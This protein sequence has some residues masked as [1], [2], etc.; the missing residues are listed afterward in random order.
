MASLHPPLLSPVRVWVYGL[1]ISIAC[2]VYA[3]VFTVAS[4]ILILS[5]LALIAVILVATVQLANWATKRIDYDARLETEAEML[6]NQLQ[7]LLGSIPNPLASSSQTDSIN[8]LAL[9]GKA[10]KLVV[11]TSRLSPRV[12]AEMAAACETGRNV[13]NKLRAQRAQTTAVLENLDSGVLVINQKGRVTLINAAAKNFFSISW[14]PVG[15]PLVEAIRQPELLNAV[16]QVMT[17]RSPR[18]VV[19]DLRD[20]TGTRRVLRVWCAAVSFED[21]TAVLLA[22]RDE[23]ENHQVEE[24]RREFV[25]NVSHE[26]K[27]PLAAIKGYAETVELAISDDPQAAIHFVS[28]IHEQCRRLE[29]LIADMM[30]LARAQAGKQHLRPTTIDLDAVIAESIATYAPVA[31]AKAISLRHEPGHEAAVVYAD[32][33]ATLTIANNVIGNAIRYTPEGGEV[34][35]SSRQEGDFSVF[36]VRDN[37]IGIPQ[38]EQQKVFERFY[39]ADKSRKHTSS[40]TGLGLAIVKN[41]TLAQG[42]RVRLQ[43]RPGKGSTFEI[44]LPERQP[45][46]PPTVAQSPSP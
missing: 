43:S 22:A 34:V 14:N 31:T 39:R 21:I 42:G 5:T 46:Q 38:H 23:S 15:K 2:F 12:V 29:R 3:I 36:A 20:Q 11:A 7:L 13:L 40:G 25:A 16:R 35:A 6:Q 10:S 18:E 33:E 1:L 41:L 37:G 24:M 26:L 9:S 27:T 45:A 17:D 32:R 28:Q 30:T 8:P 19:A 4:V 44:F